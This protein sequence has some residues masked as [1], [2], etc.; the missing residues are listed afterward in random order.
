MVLE[1]E[2]CENSEINR[3]IEDFL[4]LKELLQSPFTYKLQ[5]K[6]WTEIVL[7]SYGDQMH[8]LACKCKDKQKREN[9][10]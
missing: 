6:S 1:P 2:H 8:L 7:H 5:R 10:W 9:L 4:I 3:T